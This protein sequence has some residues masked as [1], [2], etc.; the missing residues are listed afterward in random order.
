MANRYNPENT[1]NYPQKHNARELK[2]LETADA[3][4]EVSDTFEQALLC[5]N[6]DNADGT[7]YTGA[8]SEV[9][10]FS[11]GRH[12]YEMFIATVATGAAVV[13]P[14]QSADGLELPS[15]AGGTGPD[16]VE[17]TLGNSALCKAAYTAQSDSFYIEAIVK[18]DD[19][20][21][22]SQFLLGF[23]KVQAYQTDFND[24]TDL[25]AF[26]VG[27]TVDGEL[28]I[29]TIINDAAT[30]LTD[31]TETDWANAGEHTLRIEISKQGHAKFYYDG[32]EPT[33]TA[34]FTFDADDVI[35]P[36]FRSDTE[37]GNPGVSISDFKTASSEGPG[38]P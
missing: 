27:D 10:S 5:S 35:I 26:H 7:P 38:V 37:V 13:Y 14:W 3:N 29:A 23:R 30:V 16:E 8:A 15:Q 34:S 36:F 2:L 12:L 11:S 24:Y 33:V 19:I 22:L 17:F 28:N 1:S 6:S 18:I 21:D 25:C 31:T 4:K 32:S 9:T 20:S